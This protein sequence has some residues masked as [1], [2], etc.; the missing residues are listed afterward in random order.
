MRIVL[1][2]PPSLE[3][4]PNAN[5]VNVFQG[6]E[7]SKLCTLKRYD[8]NRGGTSAASRAIL[9]AHSNLRNNTLDCN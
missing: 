8:D 6:Q 9:R 4:T 1:L 2:D 3:I 5:N 7:Y